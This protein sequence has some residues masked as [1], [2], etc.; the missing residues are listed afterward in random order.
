MSALQNHNRQQA[1]LRKITMQTEENKDNRYPL[2][3]FSG[4]LDSTCVL[5]RAMSEYKYVET[6]YVIGNQHPNK[7]AIELD[8]RREI[9]KILKK[10]HPDCTIVKDTVFD[11][12]TA[13]RMFPPVDGKLDQVTTWL[14]AAMYI[15]NG[16][17]HNEVQMGYLYSDS[18]SVFH[19]D[20]QKAWDILMNVTKHHPIPLK[21]PIEKFGKREVVRYMSLDEPE[22]FNVAWW[23]E[24]PNTKEQADDHILFE[25]C[26][27]CVPCQTMQQQFLLCAIRKY[28]H[29]SELENLRIGEFYQKRTHKH[30]TKTMTGASVRELVELIL[31]SP[32]LL[33]K[34]PELEDDREVGSVADDKNTGDCAA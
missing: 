30:M 10:K 27:H 4:G 8:R 13:I 3:V 34:P 17:K 20:M 16:T 33:V 2:I 23:C 22:L 11:M 31:P 18:S 29:T 6:M 1:A 9:E 12:N 28:G 19:R 15:A 26:G 24:D 32:P 5:D 21:F 7:S 14:Y 25:E